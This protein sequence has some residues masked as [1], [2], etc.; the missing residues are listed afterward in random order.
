MVYLYWNPLYTGDTISIKIKVGCI[1][2]HQLCTALITD[3]VTDIHMALI[4]LYFTEPELPEQR[5]Y[6]FKMM[7]HPPFEVLYP[8]TL[9]LLF[10]GFK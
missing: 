2:R 5:R 4:T 6:V 8:I 10:V 3:I 7:W 9:C 1:F